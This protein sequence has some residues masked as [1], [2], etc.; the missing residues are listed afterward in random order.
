MPDTEILRKLIENWRELARERKYHSKL[1]QSAFRRCADDLEAVLEAREYIPGNG[2]SLPY[3]TRAWILVDGDHYKREWHPRKPAAD[4]TLQG[5]WWGFYEKAKIGNIDC[6]AIRFSEYEVTHYS[7]ISM[8]SQPEATPV[9]SA[10]PAKEYW[11]VPIHVG[12]APAS[13]AEVLADGIGEYTAWSIIATPDSALDLAR[14]IRC[15][16][17]TEEQAVQGVRERV[18]AVMRT[19]FASYKTVRF[20]P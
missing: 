16:A 20:N 1:R 15:T 2:T 19:F 12:R 11:D 9:T 5:N 8:P 13:C 3:G 7:I 6:L 17:S 4:G 18:D 14:V 10:V